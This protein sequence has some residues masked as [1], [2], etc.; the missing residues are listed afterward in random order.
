MTF[1][2]ISI[3]VT[4]VKVIAILTFCC[5]LNLS[6]T[7][8]LTYVM[9]APVYS[10]IGDIYKSVEKDSVTEGYDLTTAGGLFI[11][12]GCVS[13]SGVN[14]SCHHRHKCPT[15]AASSLHILILC[16]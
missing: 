10:T 9:S 15:I 11:S 2:A 4:S 5:I 7:P 16:L 1:G 13:N 14:T 6:M 8:S 3:W 12:D